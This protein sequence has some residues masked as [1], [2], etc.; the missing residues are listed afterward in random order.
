MCR[1]FN[2]DVVEACGFIGDKMFS[3]GICH[4]VEAYRQRFQLHFS[5]KISTIVAGNSCSATAQNHSFGY[6][7]GVHRNTTTE[8]NKPSA[9]NGKQMKKKVKKKIM[10]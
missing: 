1:Y 7:A 2:Y 8:R 5:I 6:T 4:I 10:I 9:N 3:N